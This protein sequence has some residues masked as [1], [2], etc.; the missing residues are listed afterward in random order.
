METLEGSWWLVIISPVLKKGNKE[1]VGSYMLGSLPHSLGRWRGKSSLQAFPTTWRT[2]S[3]SGVVI[4]GIQGEITGSLYN[5]MTSLVDKE[6]AMDVVNLDLSE[7]FDTS[8]LTLA[9]KASSIL[10]CNRKSTG[11]TLN[12]GNTLGAVL[13]PALPTTRHG[14]TWTESS[15]GPQ[16]WQKDWSTSH[17]RRGWEVELFSL[18][19]RRLKRI[20]SVYRLWILWRNDALIRPL[21]VRVTS[22]AAHL[23]LY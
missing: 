14:L 3:W 21:T 10:G 4:K 15:A 1:D 5:E 13:S 7:V 19:K 23:Q 20:S 6:R 2:G 8:T 18:T 11:S 9:K 12:W 17:T 16:R 22:T